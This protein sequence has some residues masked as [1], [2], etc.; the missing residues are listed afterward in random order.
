MQVTKE[1]N[2]YSSPN[3]D[4][5]MQA[6]RGGEKKHRCREVSLFPTS[7][8]DASSEE[9]RKLRHGQCFIGLVRMCSVLGATR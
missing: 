9:L 1:E 2:E 3:I 8:A 7:S 6:F 4:V 5:I